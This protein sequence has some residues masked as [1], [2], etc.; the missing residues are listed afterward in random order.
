[1]HT[2]EISEYIPGKKI[3]PNKTSSSG[4][5]F[6]DDLIF[7]DQMQLY[8]TWIL[9]RKYEPLVQ[10]IPSWTGFFIKLRSSIKIT[11]SSIGYLDCL[12]APAT[13]IS[14]I[15]HMLDRAVRI[16]TQLNVQSI[17]CVYDQAIYAK[18]Y[19]IK[20]KNPVKFKDV[21][22]MMG[23]FHII[24]TFLAVIAARFKDAGLKD[25]VIQ[26][27]LVA[28]GSVD[29]MFSGSRAYKRAARVYKILYEAFSRILCE[30]FEQSN[31]EVAAAVSAVLE[32]HEESIDFNEV[33]SSAEF[34]NYSNELINFKD[35]LAE[36]SNLAK[37]WISF[38]DMCETLLNLLFATRSG[39]W[40]LY[41][42]T[43]RQTL[44]W[45][46]A[47]DRTNYSRYLTAHFQD[48][49]N[50]E[51]DFPDIHEEFTNGNFSVQLSKTNP[52]GRMEA[53]K[54]IETT[55]N[56]DTKTPGGTTGKLHLAIMILCSFNS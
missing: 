1:M 34:L 5:C 47:Y 28:E 6:V 51:E 27:M 45:L 22:L 12:N 13:D 42:A 17:V 30:K 9:L 40:Y 21:F 11:P 35:K 50:L 56:K 29:T 55:I 41:L 38:L 52:F 26:S 43:L 15:Y 23:T 36:E 14:T 16:K 7:A 20:C 53:D 48:L 19:Q 54:V 8:H 44:P 2:K 24:M 46:F 25:I 4:N 32:T 10:H 31:Q 18:A 3:G 37:Y 39:N 33:I 49:M